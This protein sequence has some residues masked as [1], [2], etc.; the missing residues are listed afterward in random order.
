[1]Q[2]HKGMPKPSGGT[3]TD[4]V[5]KVARAAGLALLPPY[6]TDLT[7]VTPISANMVRIEALIREA[8]S[9]ATH[10]STSMPTRIPA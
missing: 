8:E 5:N 6:S 9:Q 10:T 1:M 3:A 7:A 4:D 2:F